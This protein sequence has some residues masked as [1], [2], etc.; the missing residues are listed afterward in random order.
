MSYRRRVLN[1]AVIIISFGP[2]ARRMDNKRLW[3]QG[4][5]IFLY[6]FVLAE[7]QFGDFGPLDMLR[8][9]KLDI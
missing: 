8:H 4:N 7:L 9:S 2:R 3:E 1:G 6:L 5:K